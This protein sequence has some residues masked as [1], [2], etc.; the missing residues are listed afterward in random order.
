MEVISKK[1]RRR[2]P[3]NYLLLVNARHGRARLDF[4]RVIAEMTSIA[5]PFIEVWVIALVQP[6]SSDAIL[7]ASSITKVVRVSPGGFVIDLILRE[8]FEKASAQKSFVRRLDRGTSTKIRD[9]GP[10]YIPIPRG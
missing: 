9:L 8:E 7:E 5:S 1:C 6:E 2:Y 3:G 4:D 10:A